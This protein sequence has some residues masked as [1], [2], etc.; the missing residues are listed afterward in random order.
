MSK[1]R[2]GIIGCGGRGRAHALGYKESKDVEMVA[3]A[4]PKAE[5]A[6]KL[7]EE[8]RVPKAY[9]DYREMLK[10]EKLDVVSICTWIRLHHEMVLDSVKA[11][12]KAI[13]AEKPVAP[14]WGEAR[15]MQKACDD[16]GIIVT[17]CHQ[18]RFETRFQ[19]ARQLVRDGAIGQLTRMEA[20]CSNLFDWGTHWFDMLLFLNEQTPVKWVTG[21]IDASAPR[22]VFG[23][24][25]ENSGISFFACENGVMGMVATG[26]DHGGRCQIRLMGTDGLIEIGVPEGWQLRVLRAGEAGWQIPEAVKARET[27]NGT[28]LA[29]LDIIEALKEG[30]EPEL[31]GRKAMMAT[32][33]IFA[34][35]ESSRRRARVNLPLEISDSPLLT[36]L[37]S[38][39]IGPRKPA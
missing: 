22:E 19:T 20:F 8:Y 28:T 35:Y 11:G 16:A 31:S 23:V 6:K 24:P 39:A 14:T 2:V 3:C 26:E 10:K 7:Q 21:Q 1:L 33:L 15:E 18:R 34:T 5:N 17:Y 30:R 38:G 9:S 36:M 25:V 37:E 12:V 29:T 4:D 13:H 27:L 32:E